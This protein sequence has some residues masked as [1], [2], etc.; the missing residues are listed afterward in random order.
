M[1]VTGAGSELSKGLTSTKGGDSTLAISVSTGATG[2]EASVNVFLVAVLLPN[3]SLSSFSRDGDSSSG[4]TLDRKVLSVASCTSPRGATPNLANSPGA[5]TILQ[6]A[7]GKPVSLA[8]ED[9]VVGFRK[10]DSALKEKIEGALKE[11]AKDGTM[12]TISKKWFGEDVTT[13]SK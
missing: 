4:D 12:A 6:D 8:L 10:A 11:M 2:V 7:S 13:V 5:Y 9:Y 1:V 3:N